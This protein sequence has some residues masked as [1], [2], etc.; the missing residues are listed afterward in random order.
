MNYIYRNL[1][2][3]LYS[4]RFFTTVVLVLI[5]EYGMT[6]NLDKFMDDMNVKITP[7]M[8]PH[9]FSNTVFVSLFSFILCYM[10]SDVPFMNK[11]EL[12]WVL[13][14]GRVKWCINKIIVIIIQSFVFG[15]ISMFGA[16]VVFVPRLVLQNEWG[17]VIYT[18]SNSTEICIKYQIYAS[19][20]KK[21]IL[22]YT[23]LQAMG[24]CL[25]LIFLVSAFVGLLMFAV[26]L[27]SNRFCAVIVAM[28]LANIQL[29]LNYK[30]ELMSL[31]YFSP[32]TW[33]LIGCLGE[34][35]FGEKFFP[36]I[37][38]VICASTICILICIFFILIK[39]KRN[40][41]DWYKE[42]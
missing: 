36:S 38:Y 3:R 13:R 22:N 40:E 16:T 32:F 25:L 27:Y 17:K 34:R 24:L 23:P 33:L 28:G 41:F 6:M 20:S 11:T 1:M 14:L 39:I 2:L 37:S 9:F 42:E 10:F 19:G 30:P 26:S 21:I 35:S 18:I 31:Y 15:I 12:Y 5:V 4:N 7:W 29:L 8:A